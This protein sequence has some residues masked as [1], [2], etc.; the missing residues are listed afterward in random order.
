MVDEIITRQELI[1]AKLD[2]RDLGK[3]ANE[4]VI[5]SP[6]YGEDFK[7]IPLI[8]KEGEAKITQA[9]QTITSAT[10]SIVAQKNQASEVISQAESDV[11]TA[12]TDVHQRGN[13]EIINLQNAIDIAAAAGAGANGWTAQLVVDASGKTQQQ[14]TDFKPHFL[15]DTAALPNTDVTAILNAWTKNADDNQ[16]SSLEIPMNGLNYTLTDTVV[17]Q[18]PLA[19]VGDKG[20]TYDRGRGKKGWFLLGQG[21][22]RAFDLGNYRTFQAGVYDRDNAISSNQADYWTIK[23]VGIKPA[24]GVTPRSQDGLVF[25]N[26][27]N[28]PD[29][30]AYISEV[31][32]R[33]LD[34][35]IKVEPQQ[36]NAIVSICSL[37]VNDSVICDSNYGIYVNGRSFQTSIENNQIEQNYEASIWGKFDGPFRAINN[38]I[39]GATQ[40]SGIVFKN[41]TE[42]GNNSS[43]QAILESH[44]F[45]AVK[46]SC[47]DI[48]AR[49]GSA[50]WIRGNRNYNLYT[51]DYC[52]LRKGSRTTIYNE[53][54]ERITLEDGSFLNRG[55]ELTRNLDYSFYFRPTVSEFL[56]SYVS[57]DLDELNR[58][59]SEHITVNPSFSQSI[60]KVRDQLCYGITSQ[61][62]F[63]AISGTYAVGDLIEINV[64]A[65]C[66]D[67]GNGLSLNGTIG[68][69]LGTSTNIP[70]SSGKWVSSTVLVRCTVAGSSLTFIPQFN[71][72]TAV[73]AVVAGISIKN[74]GQVTIGNRY[75]IRPVQPQLHT[76][77][78]KHAQKYEY[79]GN[80]VLANGG[81]RKFDLVVSKYGYVGDLVQAALSVYVP[82]LE[83]SAVVRS[84]G[85][86]Q[87]T[88]TNPTDVDIVVPACQVRV[89]VL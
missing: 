5:V 2:A 84:G 28:G 33:Q 37:N 4:E 45:E 89:I 23:N 7:S 55:S 13:Q 68:G 35:A 24:E 60:T 30:A 17:I 57:H 32:M 58:F 72:S 61:A 87:V 21:L 3:A 22:T 10:A 48:D 71:L 50:F 88:L 85:V 59:D 38:I 67:V 31:S 39:E 62:Q 41:A 8:V 69:A 25:T 77:S 64:L 14:L 56:P 70:I 26:Q 79:A 44:Y 80:T 53:E 42:G 65:Y 54:F 27:T 9:A 51:K 15:N 43:V 36:G 74:H 18:E 52:I 46:D 73:G 12:A 19:I 75:L 47:F 1:D 29:R 76:I 11:V 16:V 49:N 63:P 83:I 34:K 78:G 82:D 40:K 20:A 86:V 81:T 6:R 66:D